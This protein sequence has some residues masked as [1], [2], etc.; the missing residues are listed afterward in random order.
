VKITPVNLARRVERWQKR[1]SL[2]GVGHFTIRQ[3]TVGDKNPWRESDRKVRASVYVPTHYDYC[4][5]FFDADELEGMSADELDQTI[6]H[7][8]LHVAMRDLDAS[9][10]SVEEY[11]SAAS[12]G[13]W[14][15]RVNHEREGFIDRL[16]WMLLLFYK[17][18]KPRFAPV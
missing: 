12:H 14:E 2:L 16:A 7:E 11:M 5:F 17:G 9:L 18:E 10:E 15:D 1:L 8:W 4:M 6:I 3:V 13:E